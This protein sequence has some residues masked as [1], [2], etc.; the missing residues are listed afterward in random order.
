LMRWTLRR[1]TR[2]SALALAI[3][4]SKFS[5]SWSAL[6]VFPAEG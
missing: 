3:L 5:L 1:L 6:V 2:A 4:A